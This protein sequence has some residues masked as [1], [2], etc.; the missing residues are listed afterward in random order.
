M[1]TRWR[2]S[3]SEGP[4]LVAFVVADAEPFVVPIE[5]GLSYI[6]VGLY[7]VVL[8]PSKHMVLYVEQYVGELVF[9]VR[10]FVYRE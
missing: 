9:W 3:H 8:G 6:V 10:V 2:D 5:H 4:L 7:R 1:Q